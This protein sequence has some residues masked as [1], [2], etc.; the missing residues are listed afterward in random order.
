MLE[1]VILNSIYLII[2]YK[3]IE[4]KTVEIQNKKTKNT[5]VCKQVNVLIEKYV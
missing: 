3:E 1:N 4:K 2:F 5:F